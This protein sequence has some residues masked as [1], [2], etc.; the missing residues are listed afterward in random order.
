MFILLFTNDEKTKLKFKSYYPHIKINADIKNIHQLKKINLILID[1]QLKNHKW[2]NLIETVRYTLKLINIPI[3]VL[4]DKNTRKNYK[5]FRYFGFIDFVDKNLQIEEINTKL[6]NILNLLSNF[7]IYTD[8]IDYYK[9]AIN[10]ID[11][12]IYQR[13][14]YILDIFM[15]T[16]NIKEEEVFYLRF[17]LNELIDNSIKYSSNY[18]LKKMIFNF[19]FIRNKLII[20]INDYGKGFDA[21]KVL[22]KSYEEIYNNALTEKNKGGVALFLIKRLTDK[23]TFNNKGNELIIEKYYEYPK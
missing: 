10:K 6:N 22:D 13:I 8:I 12:S 5:I 11:N 15:V 18:S 23:L 14:N 3:L 2:I 17:I 1:S 4:S 19:L 16:Y 7:T 20:K 9:I 21:N